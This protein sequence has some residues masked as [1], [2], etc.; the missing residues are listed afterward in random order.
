MKRIIFL[1]LTFSVLSS[2]GQHKVDSFSVQL[3]DV[4]EQMLGGVK[5]LRVTKVTGDSTYRLY[6][7]VRL[8]GV[9]PNYISVSTNLSGDSTLTF[10]GSVDSRKLYSLNNGKQFISSWD[11]RILEALK[12]SPYT[13]KRTVNADVYGFPSY[14]YN[15][16]KS[17]I[18]LFADPYGDNGL[19]VILLFIAT[20][21]NR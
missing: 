17:M 12:R 3:N 1:I 7:N 10:S 20:K 8:Q 18:T 14:T 16:E 9:Q 5:S 21:H 15:S 4:I 19:F 6:H 11:N 13:W 2:H